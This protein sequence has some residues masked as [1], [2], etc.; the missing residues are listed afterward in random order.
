MASTEHR[1]G[2]FPHPL[3]QDLRFSSEPCLPRAAKCLLPLHAH[4]EAEV[5]AN[6]SV[7]RVYTFRP[8]PKGPNA[9]LLDRC[10]AWVLPPGSFQSSM[11]NLCSATLGGGSL[12]LSFAF[13]KAS[14]LPTL[15]L[16]LIA[17]A[18]TVYS[19]WLLIRIYTLT[20]VRTYEES[21]EALVGIKMR[22]LVEGLTIAFCYGCAVAYVIAVGD[23]LAPLEPLWPYWSR[24]TW[25]VLFWAVFMLP[26]SCQRAVNSLRFTSFFGMCAMLYLTYA[27]TFHA[28]QKGTIH[29]DVEYFSLRWDAFASMP[30]VLF[31]YTCQVNVF[32]IYDELVP[33]TQQGMQRVTVGAV[34]FCFI[35]YCLVGISGY[36]E[37][38]PRTMGNILLNYDV[39]RST[40]IQLAYVAMAVALTMGFPLVMYPLRTSLSLLLFDCPQL[41]WPAHLSLTL[42]LSALI[43][44]AAVYLPGIN[45]VFQLLGSTTSSL[46][47]F[48]IP[49]ILAWKVDLHRLSQAHRLGILGTFSLG[50]F[51]GVLG[52][53]ITVMGLVAP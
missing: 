50:C 27:I 4:S 19:I 7:T 24:R 36:C 18:A 35:I 46:L 11:F 44:L 52:T 1:Y 6:S 14:I 26:P 45:V 16:L 23:A 2:T 38:G 17:G 42:F 48:I 33:Q 47:C 5:D 53:A 37:F 43:L 51:I 29:P 40:V 31:A 21:T 9:T 22:H 8:M 15:A 28:L 41:D 32:A 34:G 12:S 10:L 25:M 30:I 20:G 3:K 13:K 49:A 39:Q